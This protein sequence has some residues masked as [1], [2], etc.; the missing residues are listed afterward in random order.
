M[1]EKRDRPDVLPSESQRIE[2]GHG[3]V[4]VEITYT[5]GDPMR[6]TA[7]AFEVFITKG[8]SGGFTNA[9]ADALSMT[10]SVALRSGVD[11]HEL[12]DKLMGIRT[13]NVANDNGDSVL[14]IPDA[15]GIALKR[16]LEGR[17]EEQVREE[18]PAEVGMP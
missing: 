12:A 14:S 6:G 1:S 2:T 9:W 5:E 3:K 13:G 16:H 4:Y 17:I 8:S 11:T 18:D 10:L 15:V 7:D